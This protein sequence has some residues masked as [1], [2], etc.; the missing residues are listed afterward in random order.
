MYT[1]PLIATILNEGRSRGN[2]DVG[3]RPKAGHGIQKSRRPVFSGFVAGGVII[4]G[5]RRTAS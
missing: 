2:Q 3:A 4:A 1:Q 5:R